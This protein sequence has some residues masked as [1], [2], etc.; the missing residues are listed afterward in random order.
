MVDAGFEVGVFGKEA[1]DVVGVGEE[2]GEGVVVFWCLGLLLLLLLGGRGVLSRLLRDW[3][4]VFLVGFIAG[5]GAASFFF[6][7]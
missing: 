4:M 3:W 7:L 6:V 5:Y 2:E 1:G